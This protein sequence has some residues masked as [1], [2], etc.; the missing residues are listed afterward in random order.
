MVYVSVVCLPTTFEF[1]ALPPAFSFNSFCVYI[2]FAHQ[3]AHV[4][5]KCILCPPWTHHYHP[6]PS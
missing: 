5:R 6:L 2:L 4:L 3:K 1:L